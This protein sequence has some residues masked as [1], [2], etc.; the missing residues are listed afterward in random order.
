MGSL[1]A[2]GSNAIRFVFFRDHLSKEPCELDCSAVGVETTQ[3]MV[4]CP[5][6]RGWGHRTVPVQI[7]TWTGSGYSHRGKIH[8]VCRW[9][10][11][12]YGV[13]KAKA[14]QSS[15]LCLN[16]GRNIHVY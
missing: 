15:S 7:E 12:P 6:D 4:T 11:M 10:S 16:L 3:E 2:V 9:V 13:M 5:S 1:Q 14:G 8:M